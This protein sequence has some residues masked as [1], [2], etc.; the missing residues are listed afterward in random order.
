MGDGTKT[1]TGITLQTQS[2]TVEEVGFIIN[3][4]LIKFDIKCTIH[5]Q[6]GQPTI[7]ISSH[8]IKKILPKMLPYITPGMRYKFGL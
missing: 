3:I 2:F 7:Y 1:S 4:F 5:M 6:R 8:S